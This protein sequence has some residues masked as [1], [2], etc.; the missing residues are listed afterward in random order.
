MIHWPPQPLPEWLVAF[1][2]YGERHWWCRFL[3]PGFRHVFAL[4]YD[5]ASDIWLLADSKIGGMIVRPLPQ[6]TVDLVLAD[7]LEHGRWLRCRYSDGA[8]QIPR[9]C[10]TCVGLVEHL[11]GVPWLTSWTPWRLYRRLRAAGCTPW[12]EGDRGWVH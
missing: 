5:A 12:P 10:M 8:R 1:V 9:P 6:E 3:R 2:D 4:G 7:G 11:L